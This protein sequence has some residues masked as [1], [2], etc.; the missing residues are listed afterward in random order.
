MQNKY[1]KYIVLGI[2]MLLLTTRL[3][4]QKNPSYD[5]L[6]VIL[7][8]GHGGHD[9]GAVY[10]GRM[11]KDCN[12][13]IAHDVRRYLEQAG[14]RVHMTRYKDEAFAENERRD[15]KRRVQIA[16]HT[17]CRY[18]VSIHANAS[19]THTAN[20]FEIYTNKQ[21]TALAEAIQSALSSLPQPKNGGIHDGNHLYVLRNTF[22]ESVL[23]EVGYLDGSIDQAI[24]KNDTKRKEIAKQIANGILQEIK[25][26]KAK[27]S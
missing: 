3:L 8:A 6:E 5:K 16:N 24:L 4:Q 21:G 11:E 20:G 2:G 9:S 25:K 27:S 19:N 18:F 13:A 10:G 23:V 14:I 7:D 1:K 17:Q 26:Q 22:M 12:L 15:L